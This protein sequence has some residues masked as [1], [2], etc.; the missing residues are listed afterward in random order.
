MWSPSLV[1]DITGFETLGVDFSR[2]IVVKLFVAI[3]IIWEGKYFRL[4]V[5]CYC[6][7]LNHICWRCIDAYI[8]V[9]NSC[10]GFIMV[11][12]KDI[13]EDCLIRAYMGH[14]KRY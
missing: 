3:Y 1:V 14:V 12:V 6:Y 13:R 8:I 11:W 9:T 2:Y 7:C 4:N 10:L 5:I